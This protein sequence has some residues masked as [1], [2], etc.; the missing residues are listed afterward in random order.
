MQFW[1]KYSPAQKILK[2]LM[3]ENIF[4]CLKLENKFWGKFLKVVKKIFSYGS[5]K[6]KNTRI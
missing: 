6:K 5:Q 1:E 4:L 3:S 2:I